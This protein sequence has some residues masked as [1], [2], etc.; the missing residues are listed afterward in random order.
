MKAKREKNKKNVWPATSTSHTKLKLRL[1]QIKK[2]EKRYHFV[3][4]EIPFEVLQAQVLTFLCK[5][6][7]RKIAT[8]RP[9][10]DQC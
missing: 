6:V 2:R 8:L 1:G 7:Q 9:W 5:I 4:D 10:S 3:D